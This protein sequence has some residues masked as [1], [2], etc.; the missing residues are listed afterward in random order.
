M[1]TPDHAPRRSS[2]ERLRIAQERA[3]ARI[4]VERV[5]HL[6]KRFDGEAGESVPVEPNRPNDL[7]GGA[8][9][10]LEFDDD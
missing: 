2:Q 7:T 5:R 6:R 9:A 10:A 8:A 3:F 4:V 1:P